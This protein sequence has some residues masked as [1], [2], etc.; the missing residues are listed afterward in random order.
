M[1][2][3]RSW[4]QLQKAVLSAFVLLL[5]YIVLG[6]RMMLHRKRKHAEAAPEV[7][8]PNEK[9]K[10]EHSE[11]WRVEYFIKHD[12]VHTHMV[13]EG[14]GS[15]QDAHRKLIQSVS[16]T[17][18]T[19]AHP[20]A[21]L[22]YGDAGSRSSA[23]QPNQ[24]TPHSAANVEKGSAAGPTLAEEPRA[25]DHPSEED[26]CAHVKLEEE[27]ERMSADNATPLSAHA[28]HYPTEW[29]RDNVR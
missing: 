14:H 5:C 16:H 29:S 9:T 28:K 24:D 27:E 4:E 15:F 8:D 21:V 22:V 13:D 2:K 6:I 1:H 12:D 23:Q 18:P 7:D 17:P 10:Q 11:H 25:S 26:V 19:D 3:L 20:V